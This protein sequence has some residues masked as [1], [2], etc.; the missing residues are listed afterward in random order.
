MMK[1]NI[2]ILYKIIYNINNLKIIKK[3]KINFKLYNIKI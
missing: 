3:L 1:K 2:L